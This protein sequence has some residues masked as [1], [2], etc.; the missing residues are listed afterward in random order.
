LRGPAKR[1]YKQKG[2]DGKEAKN[3]IK[4]G[5]KHIGPVLFDVS[6]TPQ[7]TEKTP[8]F[9]TGERIIVQTA[10]SQGSHAGLGQGATAGT[11]SRAKLSRLA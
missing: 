11:V 1:M 3:Q 5:D 10:R 9:F 6:A 2:L 8:I 7:P 4:R